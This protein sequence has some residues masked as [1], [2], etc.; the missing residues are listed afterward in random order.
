MGQAEGSVNPSLNAELAAELFCAA[1][2]GLIYRWL[3][4]PDLSIKALHDLLKQ[5]T[6]RAFSA[7]LPVLLRVA[8]RVGRQISW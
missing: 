8:V 7:S 3:V 5:Q 1:V 4:N 2:D 6:F